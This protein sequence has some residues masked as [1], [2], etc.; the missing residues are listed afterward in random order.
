[1]NP[2]EIIQKYYTPKSEAYRILVDHS[3][4]VANKALAIARNHPE[5]NLDLEF[6][7]EAA[8]LH[9]IG[10]FKCKAESI[11]CFGDAEY[12]CH[13]YL[14]ADIMP[15]PRFGLRTAY[16]HRHLTQND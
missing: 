3:R 5:L 2:I 7:E 12:I 10:I 13:G 9:D 14:G 4:D 16:R 8:M 1:M 11:G 6:I 15:P